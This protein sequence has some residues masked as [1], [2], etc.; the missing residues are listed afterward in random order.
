[1]ADSAVHVEGVAKHFVTTTALAGVDLDVEE[2]TVFGL[3]GPNGAGKTTL[4]RVSAT[5]EASASRQP[6][7][8]HSSPAPTS[9]QSSCRSTTGCSPVTGRSGARA[10]SLDHAGGSIAFR[11]HAR[12]GHLVLSARA[13]RQIAFRVLLDAEAL[14]LVSRCRRRSGRKRHGSGRPAVTRG[15]QR[16]CS[17]TSSFWRSS[18]AG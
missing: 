8:P 6:T 17:W 1:M 18:G 16:L 14:G 9:Y 11:F 13:R 10:S 3:L 12:D 15:Q 4:V 2:A 7:V 5:A